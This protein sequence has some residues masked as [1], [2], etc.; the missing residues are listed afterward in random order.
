MPPTYDLDEQIGNL[1][2]KLERFVKI[3]SED[4]LGIQVKYVEMGKVAT[5]EYKGGT[6]MKQTM[7]RARHV[8]GF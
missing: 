4:F 5:P 3:L 8:S 7:A 1:N 6:K 2:W